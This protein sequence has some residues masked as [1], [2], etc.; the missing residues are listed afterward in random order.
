MSVQK[1]RIIDKARP[2]TVARAIAAVVLAV[3]AVTSF[4]SPVAARPREST[5]DSQAVASDG[6][7]TTI[8]A[9]IGATDVWADG[10]TGDGVHVA[11]IDTGVAPVAGLAGPDKVVAIVDLS[12]EASDPASAFIDSFGHGTHVSGIIAGN[13]PDTGFRGVAPGAG[14]VSVKVA[15]RD[16]VA[17]VSQVITAIDW[18][19]EHRNQ[20]GLNIRVLNLA[21]GTD[22]TQRY[23]VDPLAEAVERAWDA[24]IVV[25]VAAGNDGRGERRLSSPASD[26]F[27][28]AVGA[29]R[30]RNS[31]VHAARFST[32]G[33]G[34]RDPDILAPGVSVES[35][36]APGSTADLDHPDARIGESLFLGSGTSQSAAVVSGGVALLLEARPQ[37]TPDQVKYLLTTT[38]SRVPGRNRFV[39][40]GMLD[41]AAAAAAPVPGVE[42][43]QSWARSTGEGSLV[44]SRG[45]LHVELHGEILADDVAVLEDWSSATWSSASWSNA[46]WSNATWSNATWSNATWSNATWSNATWSNATW[47]NA[48]WSSASWST[49]GWS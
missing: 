18:V 4:V 42:S 7:L 2:A 33:D 34:T 37:L 6:S 5:P 49:A 28:I 13:D 36:R 10:F 48:T 26:P 41:L 38:A 24:G 39:G 1:P 21:Y 44:L 29:A 22:S 16:G 12:F 25:V 40:H 17:D 3:A 35:L 11:V 45:S 9:L 20:D 32:S 23:E 19:V 31:N 30:S 43:I 27:V 46:T 8:N 14:L 47:S 15:D